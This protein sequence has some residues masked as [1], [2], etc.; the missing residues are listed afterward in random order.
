MRILYSRIY[1]LLALLTAVIVTPLPYS[2]TAAVVLLLHFYLLLKN[3]TSSSILPVN[4]LSILL[5]P[6]LLDAIMPALLS[7]LLILPALPLLY[8][9]LSSSANDQSL[10]SF[11]EKTRISKRLKQITLALGIVL[12]FSLMTDTYVLSISVAIVLL[13]F[14]WQGLV[15]FRMISEPFVW[16]KAAEIQVIAGG[17]KQVAYNLV[18]KTAE[19]LFVH[20][21][22]ADPWVSIDKTSLTI[23]GSGQLEITFAPSL[24]GPK[25]ARIRISVMDSLGLLQAGYTV[26]C[27][28]LTVIPRA[29]Y[30]AFL[31]RK[32][33]EGGA[34]TSVPDTSL[35]LSSLSLMKGTG[36]EY[37]SSHIYMPGDSIRSIDWKH[38]ARYRELV[39]KK[40]RDDYGNSAIIT[41][42]LT[43]TSADEA[44]RVSNSLIT[45]VFA[46]AMNSMRGLLVVYD[47]DKVV[48]QTPMMPANALLKKVLN[49]IENITFTRASTRYL[50]LP[51]I[52]MLNR[53]RKN[54]VNVDLE[55][56]KRLLDILDIEIDAFKMSTSRHPLSLPMNRVTAYI[57]PPAT[58]I[59]I[60]AL[61]HDAEALSYLLPELK[62]RGYRIIDPGVNKKAFSAISASLS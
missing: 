40:Y 47:E 13:F 53:T 52:M 17:I 60:T 43:A 21:E 51:D 46:L 34:T 8:D 39:V 6:V 48:L 11:S 24:A 41:A 2:I 57:P 1:I 27:A 9:N 55:P 31:A 25:E 28:R 38:T 59:P 15:A 10:L 45:S 29:R 33:L 12:L 35:S 5:L 37:E 44:D 62:A 7:A 16:Q 30:S 42:N 18:S 49:L 32:Y 61:N 26:D 19:P 54:L 56:A 50:S 20:I 14:I 23:T 3:V 58:I 36:I 22:A 4:L